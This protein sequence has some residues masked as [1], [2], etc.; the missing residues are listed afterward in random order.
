MNLQ[1]LLKIN[2]K[3]A[4]FVLLLYLI[5]SIAGTID[6][7][8]FQFA[9]N[10]LEDGNL[11]EYIKWQVVQFIPAFFGICILPLADFLFNQQIQD[12]IDDLRSKMVR[13]F[14]AKNDLNVTQMQNNLD[15]LTT[16]YAL[17]WIAIISN[18]FIILLSVG[19]LL[20]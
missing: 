15:T 18:F 5:Y 7:Y 8:L 9:V 3:R 17:S 14:Y 11:T 2:Q 16:D 20:T 4:T 12:Y 10:S 13:Y 6:F 1:G 19:A